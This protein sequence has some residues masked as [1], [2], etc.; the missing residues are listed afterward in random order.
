MNL[1]FLLL[2]CGISGLVVPVESKPVP[3]LT[4]LVF[5]S[6]CVVAVGWGQVADPFA[7]AG[8][9]NAIHDP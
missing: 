1:L 5:K 3:D 9:E 2:F 4:A 6:L 7:G 8:K